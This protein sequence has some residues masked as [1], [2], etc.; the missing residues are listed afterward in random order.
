MDNFFENRHI[1]SENFTKPYGSWQI[2]I[3][4]RNLFQTF[5]YFSTLWQ[6]FHCKVV[7][8]PR[9]CAL[10]TWTSTLK[11]AHAKL[12]VNA[13]GSTCCLHVRGPHTKVLWVTCSLPAKPANFTCDYATSTSYRIQAKC[14]QQHVFWPEN[15]KDFTGT[16][17]CVTHSCLPA[18]DLQFWL[19]LLAKRT[20]IWQA[21][22]HAFEDKNTRNCRQYCYHNTGN[23]TFNMEVC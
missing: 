13:D 4:E 14:L 11:L 8:F 10:H 17:T 1:S 3:W 7:K 15:S 18:S 12:R 6:S 9:Q 22:G 19:F 21:K 23:L 16:F 2:L 20:F 5:F